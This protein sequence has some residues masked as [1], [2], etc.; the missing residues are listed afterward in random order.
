MTIFNAKVS[1]VNSENREKERAWNDAVKKEREDSL[2]L[3]RAVAAST[4]SANVKTVEVGVDTIKVNM[5][6]KKMAESTIE[7]N[8]LAKKAAESTIKLNESMMKKA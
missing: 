6:L 4:V 7:T 3:S 8:E 2:R 1:V 5:L